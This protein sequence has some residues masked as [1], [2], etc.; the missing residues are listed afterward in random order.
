M[1]SQQSGFI[2][3]NALGFPRYANSQLFHNS[4]HGNI[5][6]RIKE[7]V[8]WTNTCRS[9]TYTTYHKRDTEKHDLTVFKKR[10]NFKISVAFNM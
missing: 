8:M 5:V 2:Y 4:L 1:F 10:I 9:N 6:D 3:K 7:H